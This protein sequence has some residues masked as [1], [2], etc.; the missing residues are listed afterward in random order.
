MRYTLTNLSDSYMDVKTLYGHCTLIPS[1]FKYE[2]SY[3][4]GENTYKR[5][6]NIS[7]I[8][9]FWKFKIMLRKSR[10]NN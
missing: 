2:K 3:P 4:T 5:V 7:F 1:S 10:K 8:F 9:L 6:I